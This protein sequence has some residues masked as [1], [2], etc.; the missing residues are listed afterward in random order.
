[1]SRT[2]IIFNPAARGEKAR[3]FRRYIEENRCD[4]A[5][6]PTTCAGDARRLARNAVESG[7]H[8]IVA[9]GGDGTL[10]EVLNGLAEAPG[11]FERAR[12]GVLP[13][14]TIN[15]FAR[16]LRLPLD[17]SKVCPILDAAREIRID[18]GCAEFLR[19][20]RREQRW[21][22]QLAGAGLDARSVE[23]VNWE[24][25]KKAGPAAYVIAGLQALTGE[26]PRI[27]IQNGEQ[28]ATGD[29]ILIGNGRFYGGNFPLFHK[30]D[31]QDGLL[32][33]VVFDK[34]DWTSLPGMVWDFAW[35]K[36]F[37]EG[38]ATY[39]Q[40]KEF[41]LASES[42]A[43]LQLEGE[44]AGELPATITVAPRALRVVVP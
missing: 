39:L 40:G 29:L 23:L 22:L 2:C 1:M 35:G 25:K 5:L 24:I 9:A 26:R 20:G 33:A 38:S 3:K 12:L 34:I 28:R 4:W 19:E 8:T 27:E 13:L 42:P 21:F 41:R 32:D 18:A 17:I 7:F 31:L 6:T 16:E 37:K 43:S 11:G 36:Y 10:N 14:G 30:S 15:V 44:L